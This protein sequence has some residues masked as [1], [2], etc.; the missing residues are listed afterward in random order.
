MSIERKDIPGL[1]EV[2]EAY[3]RAILAEQP[4]AQLD[5]A[6]R[7]AAERHAKRG[8]SRRWFWS[9]AIAASFALGFVAVLRVSQEPPAANGVAP[10]SQQATGGSFANDG[11]PRDLRRDPAERDRPARISGKIV[12]DPGAERSGEIG[13]ASRESAALPNDCAAA[14]DNAS[15]WAACIDALNRAGFPA[16]ALRELAAFKA[17]F[18]D[19]TL[20]DDSGLAQ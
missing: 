17:R 11:A 3:E 15:A 1:A 2:G 5:Q 4:P 16:E 14:A 8:R 6:I 20:L 12:L 18:P 13:S 9:G 10:Q 19:S 7:R